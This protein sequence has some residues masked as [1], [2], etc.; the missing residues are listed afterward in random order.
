[1]TV[2]R[3]E[4]K[5][6]LAHA[7]NSIYSD[8]FA[9]RALCLE[10]RAAAKERERELTYG[11]LNARANQ[12]A[13]YLS[14]LGVGPESLVGVC[15]ERSLDWLVS[16]LAIWKAGGAFVPLDPNYPDAHLAYLL[17][18]ARPE[19]LLTRTKLRARFAGSNART[20]CLDALQLERFPAD[21]AVCSATP[22][23]LAY[24]IYTS[25]STGRPKGVEITHRAVLNH[26]LVISQ[27]YQLCPEDR[28]LQF[29]SPS[30]DVSIEEI[31][32]SW[33]CGCTVVLRPEDI[34]SSPGAFLNFVAREQISVLNLPTAF[35]HALMAEEHAGDWPSSVRLVVIGGERAS[36]EAYR[37]WKRRVPG[38]VKL[39]NAYGPTEATVT[40]MVYEADR[41]RDT[42]PIGRPVT[43]TY[44]VV[45]DE[46]LRPLSAGA[47]GELYL[48]GS[49]LARGYLNRPEL[50]AKRFIEN[51]FPG[52]IPSAR[53]YRTGDLV[54]LNPEGDF[55]FLGRVDEQVKVRGF[56]IE[57]G[58]IEA[59]LRC[60]DRVKDAAVVARE[61]Q[62]GHKRLVAYVIAREGTCPSTS[63]LMEFLGKRLPAYMVPSVF[64]PMRTWPLTSGGKLDRRALPAPEACRTE[65]QVE[66]SAPRSNVEEAVAAIWKEVLRVRS[67]G[68]RDNFLELGG[69]S[70]LGFQV[71]A[72][73][74]EKFAVEL[75]LS[76]LFENPT[77][78]G[79][80][81][82]VKESG[83]ENPQE[84]RWES[85]PGACAS[86]APA[87]VIQEQLFF[88]HEL[89][90]QRDPYHMSSCLRLRGRVDLEALQ[91]ALDEVLARHE[92]LRTALRYADGS[93]CQ[94]VLS[95]P[96][97]PLAVLS[98]AHVPRRMRQT[99]LRRR[100]R[101]ETSREFD[102]GKAPLLRVALFRVSENDQVL[103]V[104]F[105]HT[106]ADGWSLGIFWR[107]L[108][109]AY[110]A[111]TASGARP[112]DGSIPAAPY[113]DFARWQ[114]Q[115][116][117][118]RWVESALAFWK[119]TL[120]GAPRAITWPSQGGLPE[121]A[122][123]EDAVER[124]AL[125]LPAGSVAAMHGTL[126]TCHATPFM[127]L[128]AVLTLVVC[129]WTG[130]TDLVIG[131]VAA[132][133]TRREFE[134]VIGC[135]MNILPLRIQVPPEATLREF[136][137]VVRRTVLDAQNYQDCPF[138]QI[139]MACNGTAGT[140]RNPLFNLALLWHNYPAGN[141]APP[142]LQVESFPIPPR[143]P[144]LDLRFEAEPQGEEWALACE[145]DTAL[146]EPATIAQVLKMFG[147]AFD[148]LADSPD[149]A[150]RDFDAAQMPRSAR[151]LRY[152]PARWF[153]KASMERAA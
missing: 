97:I 46:E 20:A 52:A 45:L 102:L 74:R 73:V 107:E 48:A 36:E 146:F 41:S 149:T 114:R 139:A 58:E 88:I 150:L 112:L 119:N 71:L 120:A 44:G 26:S 92:A 61:D 24:V 5:K 55:E 104:T 16:L 56:R 67:V 122:G 47:T 19:V 22:E 2:D 30:F 29:A 65:P 70:L 38:S 59:A 25:G 100:I 14:T 132:G 39:I 89:D 85:G 90:P 42:L 99:E 101:L 35:W 57:P 153:G 87:S 144:L 111:A 17:S 79:L 83:S 33:L 136:L 43:N 27:L 77:I 18:D 127:G 128:M 54:R 108:E 96:H 6:P 91:Q 130:Q 8:C 142:G 76:Q 12:L 10:A 94:E 113:A 78:A 15:L 133:R 117:Q 98:L 69:D 140:E 37:R 28:V 115:L 68:T 116:Q 148:L 80:V 152:W 134:N 13:N 145:Y 32:P 93:L 129:K 64:V 63:D 3:L 7:G 21:R 125:S 9:E 126:R 95:T 138:H 106:V 84:I 147:R 49:G 81:E 60:C 135:F 66:S 143:R 124:V 103:V 75:T 137:K 118:S 131:T 105:H 123:G 53:L 72:R 4:T 1:M 50:T 110:I 11:E 40:A 31:F 151:R 23:N 82:A 62:P 109:T 141:F 121:T 86:R 34:V 51:P